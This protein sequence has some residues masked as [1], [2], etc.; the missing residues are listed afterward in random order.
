MGTRKPQVDQCIR[1]S[2]LHA[3][4]GAF[5]N[6]TPISIPTNHRAGRERNHTTRSTPRKVSRRVP[7]AERG[8]RDEGPLL[9]CKAW[10]LE[11]CPGTELN[12]RHCDFQSSALRFYSFPAN[13]YAIEIAER[14]PLL[15]RSR[16]LDRPG[17]NDAHL[18]KFTH[19]IHRR[20]APSLSR[21]PDAHRRDVRS[22]TPRRRA[23]AT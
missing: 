5:G 7:D 4:V 20:A 23:A 6:K 12:R 14:L 11:W 21:S 13:S 9:I 18:C 19:E 16:V 22:S 3:P 17:T 2:P 15:G 1:S 10:I 8:S